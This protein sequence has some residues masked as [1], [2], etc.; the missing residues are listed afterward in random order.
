VRK[1]AWRRKRLKVTQLTDQKFIDV[2]PKIINLRGRVGDAEADFIVSGKSGRGV[3]LT[4]ADRK[5]RISFLEKIL[6][7][8][9]VQV[10]AA[11]V[12][13][14]ERYP[15]LKTI[16]TDNDLLLLRH[17]ELESLLGVTLYFCHPYHSW[18]KGTIENAN[19]E[20]RKRIP[21]GSDISYPRK[22]IRCVE[23]R[24]NGRYMKC[25]NYYTP[26]EALEEHRKQKQRPT[27]RS[28]KKT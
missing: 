18:E 25:L 10:H 21:K 8:S 5:I 7:V 13:I 17:R 2:R 3:A 14:K 6:P 4:V 27:A 23:H 12:R 19:G 16:T 15:E 9:I 22:F 1:R 26:Q 28:K 11:F 20:V 24:I